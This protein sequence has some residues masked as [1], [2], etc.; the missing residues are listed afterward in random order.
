MKSDEY[1]LKIKDLH[2]STTSMARLAL[3]MSE[4]SKLMGEKEHVHFDRVQQGSLRLISRIDETAQSKVKHRLSDV[5]QTQ[6]TRTAYAAIQKLLGED[7]T[8]AELLVDGVSILKIS[9][10]SEIKPIPLP[11]ELITLRGELIKIGGS[12]NTIP[13]TLIEQRTGEKINGNVLGKDMAKDL[14]KQLYN[15]IEVVGI[16]HWLHDQQKNDWKLE[17]YLVSSFTVLKSIPVLQAIESLYAHSNPN[18]ENPLGI[19]DE[20]RGEH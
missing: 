1:E 7:K 15:Q 16:G 6:E 13:F 9:G 11:R 2:P 14:A 17:S 3:Y 10:K 20:I 8:T 18:A 4:L 12:D 19:L 5:S